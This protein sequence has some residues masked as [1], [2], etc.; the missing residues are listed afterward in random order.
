MIVMVEKD[1]RG[2]ITQS[3]RHVQVLIISTWGLYII[4]FLYLIF[5]NV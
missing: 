4:K 1:I 2:G 5:S 3:V